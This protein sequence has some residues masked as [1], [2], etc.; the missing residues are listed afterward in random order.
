VVLEARGGQGFCKCRVVAAVCRF[1]HLRL[2]SLLRAG[3]GFGVG[4]LVE[5]ASAG[6]EV[7]GLV[8]CGFGDVEDV[9]FFWGFRGLVP[10]VILVVAG[11]FGCGTDDGDALIPHVLGGRIGRLLAE[12]GHPVGPLG[13]GL[14]G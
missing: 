6:G 9:A 4:D 8:G 5:C 1:Y 13:D 3:F 14:L 11:M 7:V 2:G 12:V 10:R